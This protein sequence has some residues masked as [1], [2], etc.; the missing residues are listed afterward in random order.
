MAPDW[1]NLVGLRILFA[2]VLAAEGEDQRDALEAVELTE[3]VEQ[4]LLVGVEHEGG[5]I[6]EENEVGRVD[7]DLG[8]VVDAQASSLEHGWVVGLDGFFDEA[9]ELTCCDALVLVSVDLFE[10]GEDLV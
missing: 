6:D 8:E 2:I 5:V 3:L 1:K 10:E 4:I 7:A 9:V